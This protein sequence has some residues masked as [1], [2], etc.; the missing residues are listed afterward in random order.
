MSKHRQP[1]TDNRERAQKPQQAGSDIALPVRR[2]GFG[3]SALFTALL[4][5]AALC[6]RLVFLGRAELWQDE[7][8]FI[9]I[10]SPQGA[11][12]D[13]FRQS[14]DLIV[15]IGQLPLSFA[16]FNLVYRVFA[17]FGGEVNAMTPFMARLPAAIFG[18]LGV[19]GA[20]RLA[21][22]LFDRPAAIGAG[23][24]SS[25]FFFHVYYSREVYCYAQILCLAPFAVYLLLQVMYDHRVTWPALIGLF[26]CLTALLYTH[27]GALMLVAAVAIVIF[28]RWFF[29]WRV[30]KDAGAAR[31]A[32]AAGA[33]CAAA[34][35]AVSPFIIR[36]MLH[37]KAH[38][39]GAGFS[40][41]TILNDVI[42][43]LFL[44]ERPAAAA[45]AWLCAAAGFVHVF[46]PGARRA[47]RTVFGLI[48]LL[49]MALLTWATHR[50]QYLSARY[51]APA[52]PLL[53]LVFSAGIYQ[54]AAWLAGATRLRARHVYAVLLAAPL[55]F[56]VFVFLPE[57]LQLKNKSVPFKAIA[58]WINE[59][60][61]AGT[62]YLME[63]AY[64]IR[65]VGGAYPTPDRFPVSPYVHGSGE[66]EL[67]RL[68]DSQADFM[69]RF[70]EAP[71]IQSAHH[72]ADQ[73]GG[74]WTW[75][76]ENFR[77]HDRIAVT[78]HMR[79]LIQLGIY[80]GLPYEK[81]TDLSY[82]VDI[83][84]NTPEDRAEI[85]LAQGRPVLFDYSGW[86][87]SGR[88]VS[89]QE[90]TYFRVMPG[91]RG[92]VKMRNVSDAPANGVVRL[93]CA[94]AGGQGAQSSIE[95]L[96]N[97]APA[98]ATR[99]AIGQMFD[100]EIPAQNLAPGVNELAFKVVDGLAAVQ[101]FVLLDAQWLAGNIEL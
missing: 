77:S 34:L 39:Q 59:K 89:P 6:V 94:L 32:F 46:R 11:F 45:A 67:E 53:F 65:W 52:A 95:F 58:D 62:P 93:R 14:W 38:S 31:S 15:S 26:L 80:P 1:N 63:S 30:L 13:V 82:R 5:L 2:Q 17:Q 37:N 92:A 23:L 87:I 41:F 21:A 72:N 33:V 48:A 44:G 40:P 60:L 8:G 47:E 3:R 56:H 78:E 42:A 28:G 49:A 16:V 18:T 74:V 69:S 81:L 68:H 91:A 9:R 12:S 35:L 10:A 50:S 98:A 22:R 43:K 100:I 29:A 75:P 7:L 19:Y 101:G 51:F 90:T 20:Y 25:F 54:F 83:Y 73:P 55:A 71:F 84:F 4:L 70:P 79:R 24:M 61:P 96:V 27:M 76:R 99:A 57:L 64:E 85:A 97:N 36:F 88:Q 86:Q 66:N